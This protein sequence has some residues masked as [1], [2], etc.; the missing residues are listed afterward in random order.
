MGG[1]VVGLLARSRTSGTS[2]MSGLFVGVKAHL[3]NG[4]RLTYLVSNI[5]RFSP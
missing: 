4:V 2:V 3:L 5:V 1:G